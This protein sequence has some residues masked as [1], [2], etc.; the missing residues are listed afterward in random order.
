MELL[1]V[2]PGAVTPF[3]VINDIAGRVTV[4]L[5]GALMEHKVINCHPLNNAMTTSLKR[6][7]LIKFLE[8]TG[9]KPR[10]E[11]LSGGSSVC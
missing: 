11:R 10:I 1:G 9:H 7:D 5:D 8:A 2:I 6:N 4:V 3:G